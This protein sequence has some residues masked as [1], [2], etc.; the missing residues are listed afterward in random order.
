[1]QCDGDGVTHILP[2]GRWQTMSADTV[3]V[4]RSKYCRKYEYSTIALVE[5]ER[6]SCLGG[7]GRNQQLDFPR[8]GSV[9]M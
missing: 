1:M 4:N 2:A 9:A 8:T 5:P 7:K 6:A 3:L